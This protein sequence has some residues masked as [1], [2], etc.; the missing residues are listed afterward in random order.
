MMIPASLLLVHDDTSITVTMHGRVPCGM[1]D[2]VMIPA[3]LLLVH[4]DTSI[5]VT[6]HGSAPCGMEDT[7]DDLVTVVLVLSYRVVGTDQCSSAMF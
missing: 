4:D 1:E 5:T 7:A 6:M 2:C 3:S